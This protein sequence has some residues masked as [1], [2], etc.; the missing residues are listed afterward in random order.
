MPEKRR[1]GDL[2]HTSDL[3]LTD[4][5][6]P[7][8]ATS[9]KTISAELTNPFFLKIL[10]K[11][12][13]NLLSIRLAVIHKIM[14]V[15]WQGALKIVL[16]LIIEVSTSRDFDCFIDFKTAR[17]CTYFV[18][19]PFVVVFLLFK[20]IIILA[21]VYCGICNDYMNVLSSLK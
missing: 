19:L 18:L 21:I 7:S 20:C 11:L 2:S 3:C 15:W 16:L 6:F 17:W 13:G 8:I 10:K 4:S 12:R 9:K 1:H 5:F 14:K